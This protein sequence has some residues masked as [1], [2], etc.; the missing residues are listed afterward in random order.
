VRERVISALTATSAG[1]E[2]GSSVERDADPTALAPDDV[3]L[4]GFLFRDDKQCEL[5]RNTDL[6]PYFK[7]KAAI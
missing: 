1:T 5:I 2:F 7:C 3:A 6:R 4:I